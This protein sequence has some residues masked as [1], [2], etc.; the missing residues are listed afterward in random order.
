MLE[1]GGHNDLVGHPAVHERIVAFLDNHFAVRIDGQ[2][3][4]GDA[5]GKLRAVGGSPLIGRFSNAT[6][7]A[8]MSWV[9]TSPSWSSQ[10]LPTKPA[11]PPR[12]AIP[13]AVLAAEPPDISTAGPVRS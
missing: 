7:A 11:L 8:R 9:K 13:T 2:Q 12:D 4:E 5:L 1:N 10:T 3:V 6:P